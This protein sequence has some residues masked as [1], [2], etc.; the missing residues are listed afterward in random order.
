MPGGAGPTLILVLS[1]QV[2]ASVNGEAPMP[3]AEGDIAELT[4]EITFT[5]EADS[6]EYVA[7]Y[8]GAVVDFGD[9]A[10]SAVAV[11]V[12]AAFV[13]A[14][15]ASPDFVSAASA[16]VAP[17]TRP[18]AIAVPT[19]LTNT[20]R[21]P[22]ARPRPLSVDHFGRECAW[23]Q[24]GWHVGELDVEPGPFWVRPPK[25]KKHGSLAE[26]IGTISLA[27]KAPKSRSTG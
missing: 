17:S 18:N 13:L 16:D 11:L 15:F 27:G 19:L 14:G 23:P 26:T 25:S 10:L 20:T 21:A 6:S 2:T 4:G 9:T 1:G 7:A 24:Y 22:S 8:L 3:V 12:L 5:G